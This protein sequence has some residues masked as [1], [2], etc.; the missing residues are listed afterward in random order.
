MKLRSL[1]ALLCV[2][3]CAFTCVSMSSLVVR[4]QMTDAS[5]PATQT[6][7]LLTQQF[8]AVL[9]DVSDWAIRN[10]FKKK[11]CSSGTDTPLCKKFISH[12]LEI[13]INVDPQ[14]NYVDLLIS[15]LSGG[16][17]IAATEGSLIESLTK[18]NK[19][20]VKDKYAR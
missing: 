15:D 11:E 14:T 3:L 5:S 19:W 10:S 7:E 18:N 2:P 6:I 8:E 20:L 1:L 16:D 12:R 9:A 17:Y 4:P 13:T